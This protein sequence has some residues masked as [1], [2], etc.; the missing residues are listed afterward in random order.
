[1][2]IGIGNSLTMLR[3]GRG[4]SAS[5]LSPFLSAAHAAVPLST[6]RT[7]VA[8]QKM[9]TSFLEFAIYSALDS[10][11]VNFIRWWDMGDRTNPDQQ[12]PALGA[13]T[14][15]KLY[16]STT[17]GPIGPTGSAG[18]TASTPT[19]TQGH[20]AAVKVGTWTN[21]TANS[22][23]TSYTTDAS[24]SITYTLTVVEGGRITVEA[25]SVF[26]QGAIYK[27][28]VRSG[29]TEIAAD[30]YAT[31]LQGADRVVDSRQPGQSLGVYTVA[32]DLPA[33]TYTIALSFVGAA[34]A[35]SKRIYASQARSWPPIAFDATGAHGCVIANSDSSVLSDRT[36]EPGTVLVYGFEGVTRIDWKYWGTPAAGTA[37]FRVFDA[38]GNPVTIP[39]ASLDM[40]AASGLQQFTVATDMTAG[41]YF[42]HVD[43]DNVTIAK[44]RLYSHGAV[45]FNQGVAG[46]ATDTFD[47]L[48]IPLRPSG[49]LVV[50]THLIAGPPA[51]DMAFKAKRPGD[52]VSEFIGSVHG[53][54]S[55][56]TNANLEVYVDGVQVDWAGAAQ[57]AIF[58]GTTEIRLEFATT[59]F[60]PED[61]VT[62][63]G[64][65][66]RVVRYLPGGV[67]KHSYS[68]THDIAMEVEIDYPFMIQV[69]NVNTGTD[70][71]DSIGGGYTDLLMSS[72][73]A[74]TFDVGEDVTT[75]FDSFNREAQ[76]EN[77]T[78]AV[79]GSL[80]NPALVA[81]AYPSSA[82]LASRVL[83]YRTGFVKYYTEAQTFTTPPGWS[84]TVDKTYRVFP[85]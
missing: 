31:W 59:M 21:T 16:Q 18:I 15:A 35:D 25:P 5:S 1:M 54:E 65:C 23:A 2:Q 84:I 36:F 28:V 46:A 51:Y 3:G 58:R 61:G 7:D 34:N 26:S 17:L 48:D 45:A 6:I 27:V 14:L 8:I 74:A 81:A 64:T 20:A 44:P 42:L 75:N 56:V 76:W 40:S 63:F 71:A 37:L 73:G 24:G 70:Y 50:G 32:K 47:I 52:T 22:I 68:R 12:A 66:S 11:G 79:I 38:S 80:D 57:Y 4:G 43:L 72:D 49:G 10:G 29:A 83:N 78:W 41:D 62:P 53:F 30:K 39:T 55:T 9:D 69:P 19:A 85:T 13:G 60:V 77:G 82:V 67:V 33:G